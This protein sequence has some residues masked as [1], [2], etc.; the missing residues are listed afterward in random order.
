MNAVNIF[1]EG[2]SLFWSACRNDENFV[3]S[4]AIVVTVVVGIVLGIVLKGTSK[5][6]RVCAFL[7]SLAASIGIFGTFWGIF[8]GLSEFDST[9]IQASVP[10]LLEGMKTAFCTSLAGML[11]SLMLK[12]VYHVIDDVESFNKAK[13]EAKAN[14]EAQKAEA[15][16]KAKADKEAKAEEEAKARAE[17]EA[18]EAEKL[19]A[20]NEAKEKAEIEQKLNKERKEILDTLNNIGGDLNEI[21]NI[22]KGQKDDKDSSKHPNGILLD[23]NTSISTLVNSINDEN[24]GLKAIKQSQGTAVENLGQIKNYLSGSGVNAENPEGISKQMERS[25]NTIKRTVEEKF[26]NFYQEFSKMASESMVE[27]LTIVVDKFDTALNDVVAQSFKDLQQSTIELNQWQKE[28]KLMVE[29]ENQNMRELIDRITPL[30]DK[31]EEAKQSIQMV[32]QELNKMERTLQGITGSGEQLAQHGRDLAEQNQR[33]DE[34]LYDIVDVGENAKKVIPVITQRMNE[35]INDIKSGSSIIKSSVQSVSEELSTNVR[36]FAQQSTVFR[37]E[38][39]SSQKQNDEY[40]RQTIAQIDQNM[41]EF[42]SKTNDWTE[43]F[44]QGV[45]VQLSDSLNQIVSMMCAISNK[46]AKDYEPLADN[47][48]KIVEISKDIQLPQAQK[49]QTMRLRNGR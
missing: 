32:S 3:F 41:K 5:S 39:I 11:G 40:V 27:Q 18:K 6:S 47:L 46:F 26:D 42:S 48:K 25:A 10:P 34:S 49:Q 44:S 21:K 19:K 31:Y 45:N 14:D 1:L 22:L 4:G 36:E 7:P 37:D 35:I 2:W 29:T 9:N 15:E 13:A 24:T 12:A 8:V 20:D 17:A 43:Q 33:L 23:M 30:I 16:E 28:Y 38:L